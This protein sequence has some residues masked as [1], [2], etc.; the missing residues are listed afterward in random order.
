MFVILLDPTCIVFLSIYSASPNP[1]YSAI[2]TPRLSCSFISRS[3]FPLH[4]ILKWCAYNG[5]V[6]YL[7]CL[8]CELW[9]P[10]AA[11]CRGASHLLLCSSCY[12]YFNYYCN[13]DGCKIPAN[14]FYHQCCKIDSYG[15][16]SLNFTALQIK[17]DQNSR[18]VWWETMLLMSQKL[19]R[20]LLVLTSILGEQGLTAGKSD[21][22]AVVLILN[23][24]PSL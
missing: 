23:F 8:E 10:C 15:P 9:V 13:G 24:L 16:V 21:D 11:I 1:H 18:N 12:L 20:F 2:S 14:F 3:N 4:W 7:P 5:V 17:R 6:F 19:F 22:I